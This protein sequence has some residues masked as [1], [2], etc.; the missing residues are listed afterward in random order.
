MTQLLTPSIYKALSNTALIDELKKYVYDKYVD[1][2][3]FFVGDSYAAG[4][5]TLEFNG[6]P[7]DFAYRHP[8]ADAQFG[9]PYVWSG[10]TISTFTSDNILKSVLNICTDFGYQ[11]IPETVNFEDVSDLIYSVK[12]I[13]FEDVTEMDR[14]IYN[15]KGGSV[16]IYSVNKDNYNK[17][18]L[19]RFNT[20]PNV[21]EYTFRHKIS[22]LEGECIGIEFTIG[23]AYKSNTSA[24][25]K[26]MDGNVIQG[27]AKVQV[28]LNRCHYLIM[29]GGLNDM[30]QRGDNPGTH[31]PFGELLSSD[32]YT[33]D[34]FDDKTFCGALEHMV[35]E[36]V[37]KLPATKLGFLIMPQPGDSLWNDQYAKAIRDVCDKYGVPYLNLG[38]LKRMNI[39]SEKSE[40]SRLFWCTNTN[41][42]FNYHP[43]AIGYN[44]MMNDAIMKFIDSL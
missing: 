44:T 41:G 37:F 17:T 21:I 6:Y 28:C 32:D 12:S 16:I 27:E 35:R 34:K 15:S 24:S 33:T 25:F 13:L 23:L 20:H 4:V 8:L 31:V 1:K 42:T 7:N 14:V 36:A 10:R 18:Q 38:N 3:V 40:A 5:N 2:S 39:V 29:E 9:G 19:V 22:A 43:S 11:R 30:Y 26:T